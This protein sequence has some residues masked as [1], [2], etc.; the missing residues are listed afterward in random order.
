M[1][2][3][4]QTPGAWVLAGGGG[5]WSA[6]CRAALAACGIDPDNFGTYQQ[7]A[8]AQ[9]AAREGYQRQRV[10]EAEET[11]RRAPG[12]DHVSGCVRSNPARRKGTVCTCYE[13]A[14][15]F[16]DYLYGHNGAP[17]NPNGSMQ[18]WL[19]A[20]SQSG[21]ISGNAFYVA[22]GSRKE[23]DPCANVRPTYA[24]GQ[25]TSTGGYGYDGEL[26]F[27]MDHYGRANNP[28][29]SHNQITRREE[30]QSE[31]SFRPP[32]QGPGFT[33]VATRERAS[34]SQREIEAG[35]RGTV[36]IALRG[37]DSRANGGSVRDWDPVNDTMT[38]QQRANSGALAEVQ[39]QNAR[40][41]LQREAAAG[42]VAAQQALA[43]SGANGPSGSG[44]TDEQRQIAEDCITAAWKKS[45]NEMRD[46]AIMKSSTA[47]NS[48]EATAAINAYNA[49]PPPANP[50][51]KQFRDL[52][53]DRRQA[54]IDA[55]QPRVAQRQHELEQRG[56]QSAGR[57]GA[58]T[59]PPTPKDC[60]EYQANWLLSQR[61]SSGRYP[62]VSGS[63]QGTN[64]PPPFP[65]EARAPAPSTDSTSAPPT[66]L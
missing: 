38:A 42:N 59:N 43:A 20:N 55:V 1:V 50:K 9:K 32:V 19:T 52:P 30:N 56:A 23:G 31:S 51:I 64:G 13:D 2:A 16:N 41:L 66:T 25:F 53:P 45:L 57:K 29:T 61:T 22:S 18:P 26:A 24:S 47:A 58:G 14:S 63:P 40:Q 15:A 39:R 17:P 4:F 10:A 12:R 33:A 3:V 28:G 8:E 44:P 65:P 60:E 54:V 7:R 37:A 46:E 5:Y 35:V 11:P 21:H 49:G 48:P 6:E 34:L 27:C 36:D 62:P